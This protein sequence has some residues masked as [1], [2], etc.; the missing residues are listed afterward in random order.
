MPQY[1]EQYDLELTVL[2]YLL[3]R[4]RFALIMA[5]SLHNRGAD[6]GFATTP[7]PIR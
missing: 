4:K 1:F 6:R 2:Y 3:I 7:I 5:F